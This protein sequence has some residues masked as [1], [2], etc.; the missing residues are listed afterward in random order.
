MNRKRYGI[1]LLLSFMIFLVSC[2]GTPQQRNMLSRAERLMNNHPDSVLKILDSARNEAPNY[3]RSLRMK[4]EL[5]HA[6]AQNKA[7][8]NF[9]SDSVMKEVVDYYDSH[10][11]ANEQLQAHYVLGCV[12][13]DLNDAPKALQ[14]YQDAVD[15]ADTTSEDCNYNLLS[16]VYNVMG[17]IYGRQ[18][19]PKNSLRLLSFAYRYALRSKDTVLV[20]NC[21]EQR[22]DAYFSLKM[23]DSVIAICKRVSAMYRQMNLNKE[24][25]LAL[26]PSLLEHLEHGAIVEA[27]SELDY[28]ERQPGILDKNGKISGNLNLYYFKGA[29]YMNIGCMDSAAYYYRRGLNSEENLTNKVELN[30]GMYQMYEKLGEKDSTVKYVERWVSL[31]DS[32]YAT[33]STSTLQQMQSLYDY[34]RSQK[35]AKTKSEEARVASNKFYTI[36]LIVVILLFAFYEFFIYYKRKKNKEI[37]RLSENLLEKLAELDFLRNENSQNLQDLTMKQTEYDRLC[38]QSAS[39]K[40]LL[41]LKEKD[42]NSIKYFLAQDKVLLQEKAS[43]IYEIK[44]ILEKYKRVYSQTESKKILD[45]LCQSQIIA[46]LK[47]LA[48][49]GNHASETDLKEL[50]QLIR[51]SYTGFYMALY[52]RNYHMSDRERLI[53]ILVKLGFE[54]SSIANILDS[55][56]SAISNSKKIILSKLFNKDGGAKDFDSEM[57]LFE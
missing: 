28:I 13:R 57:E 35:I 22:V 47:K 3:P 17:Y 48:V 25:A 56:S 39:D 8:I 18:L 38:E 34:S 7:Y 37:Q 15:K 52:E 2:G 49:K 4:Y 10:G 6:A 24:S 1:L 51:K 21:Y 32:L 42:L 54:T 5:L 43:E 11:T 23:K 9:T 20:I 55:S 27:K 14:C 45:E 16:R 31:Y 50:K 41:S 44:K 26:S 53:C 33:L 19:D 36:L 29:Y 46:K 40:N 30:Q 12:Y